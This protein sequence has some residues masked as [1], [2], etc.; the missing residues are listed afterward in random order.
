MLVTLMVLVGF[1]IGLYGA[2]W[3][4]G[5]KEGGTDPAVAVFPLVVILAV[6]AFALLSRL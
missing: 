3:S 5:R 4:I 1:G 2:I 6:I